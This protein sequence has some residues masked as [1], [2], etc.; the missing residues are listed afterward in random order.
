MCSAIL[1]ERPR[2]LG[3]GSDSLEGLEAGQRWIHLSTKAELGLCGHPAQPQYLGSQLRKDFLG[4]DSGPLPLAGRKTGLG[5]RVIPA[6][7]VATSPSVLP[8]AGLGLKPPYAERDASI[9][10][11]RA[12]DLGKDLFLRHAAMLAVPD[13]FSQPRRHPLCV[14]ARRDWLDAPAPR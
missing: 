8:N 6:C 13:R 7:P 5:N 10:L 11:G 4:R 12:S 1:G 14:A 9:L 3:L 2:E